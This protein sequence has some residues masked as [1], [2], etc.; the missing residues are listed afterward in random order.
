MTVCVCDCVCVTVCVCTTVYDCVW[1]CVTVCVCV[2]L[3]DYVWLY[4]QSTTVKYPDQLIWQSKSSFAWSCCQH[5]TLTV[6]INK[7][8][9]WLE[10]DSTKFFYHAFLLLL[11]CHINLQRN[12]T[13]SIKE[14]WPNRAWTWWCQRMTNHRILCSVWCVW[15][16]CDYVWLCDCM[17]VCLCVTVNDCVCVCDCVCV[18]ACAQKNTV[19]GLNLEDLQ[20]VDTRRHEY[21]RL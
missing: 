14:A 21:I 13:F 6:L 7:H 2:C 15:W 10:N 1:L 5:K 12:G 20:S 3:C 11:C 18:G 19:S 4:V 8:V 9:Q 16:L 17:T